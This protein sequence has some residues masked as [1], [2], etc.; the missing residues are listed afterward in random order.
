[1]SAGTAIVLLL[2]VPVSAPEPARDAASVVLVDQL[3]REDALERHRGH[4]VLAMVVE[5]GGLR[6]LRSWEQALRE[7]LPDLDFFRVAD[8]PQGRGITRERILDRLEGRVPEEISILIDMEGRWARD[9]DLDTSRPNLLLFDADLEV[10]QQFR[11][12]PSDTMVDLVV[13]AV[14]GLRAAGPSGSP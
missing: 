2:A 4:P 13:E 5:V 3:G 11:G 12:G 7:R 8:V 9:L 1:M 10:T 6:K 14:S